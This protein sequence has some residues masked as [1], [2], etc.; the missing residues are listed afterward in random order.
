MKQGLFFTAGKAVFWRTIQYGGEKLIF[1]VRLVVLARLLTPFD[2][3]LLAAA[4]LAIEVFMRLSNLGMSTALVQ[5]EEASIEHYD[6]AWTIDVFRAIAVALIVFF[7]SPLI[8]DYLGEPKVVN[9]L[10][11]LALRPIL[12]ASASTMIAKFNRE[13]DFRALVFL[14]LPKAL[15]NTLLSI[16]LAS[17]FG[18]WALV[19]GNLTGA[20][21]FLVL[22]YILAPHRPRFL[23]QFGPM[24][25]LAS[26][27]QWVLMTSI[28]VMVSQTIL[29][30]VISRQLGAAELGLYYLAASLAFMPTDI[31]NQIIGPVTFPF[32]SRLQKDFREATAAF[33]SI[34][35]SVA[36]LLLPISILMIALTPTLINDVFGSNWMGTIDIIRVLLVVNVFGI[37]GETIKPILN[38][39]G[40]P[41][42]ILVM[43]SIRSIITISIVTSLAK[44]YGVVGAA[45]AGLPSVAVAQ[46][47]GLYFLHT[48]L[49]RPFSGLQ[50]P[51]LTIGLVSVIGALVAMEIDI[52]ITGWAG[53]VLASSLGLLLTGSL[54]FVIE[55]RFSIGLLDGF[56]KA[57]PPLSN[58]IGLKLSSE[59]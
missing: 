20:F 19:A 53:F 47:V 11:A 31:A 29:K 21:V 5:L 59:I 58:W 6:S 25:P 33:K 10:R 4:S 13:L 49:K 22:S 24:R 2:F 43:E 50:A 14:Q 12:D 1:L 34:F 8:A 30:A 18:V 3:G 35:V 23:L 27:G 55:R 15:T 45:F 48:L 38:G 28:V 17:K 52:F 44:T 7:A 32:Y 37:L 40:H 39:T 41:D 26:F 54:L 56:Q 46:L 36:V 9:V 42:K 16:I 57:F 51:L